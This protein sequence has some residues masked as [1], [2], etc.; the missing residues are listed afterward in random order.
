[1]LGQISLKH[2][3][4]DR[5]MLDP[6]RWNADQLALETAINKLVSSVAD[7]DSGADSMAMTPIAEL[8]EA[9]R[10]QTV[11]EALVTVLRGTAGGTGADFIKSQA[12]SGLAGDTVHALIVA[13]KAY[14]DTHKD[15]D[16]HDERYFTEA[17]ITALFA[18]ALSAENDK[19]TA[20]GNRNTADELALETHKGSDD[21]DLR[22]YMKNAVDA[23]IN[24][25]MTAINSVADF[26]TAH[27]ISTDHDNRYI[28]RDNTL[29]F[30][31]TNGG[32]PATKAYVDGVLAGATLGAIADGSIEEIKIGPTLLATIH[33]PAEDIGDITALTTTAKTDLVAAINEVNAKPT[34][35]GSGSVTNDMLAAEIKPGLLSALTTTAK[36]TFVAAINELVTALGTKL[37][38]ASYTAADVFAKAKSINT[39]S[40]LDGANAFGLSWFMAWK[41]YAGTV[42]FDASAGTSPTGSAV[43]SATPAQAWQASYPT[44]MGWNGATTFGVRVDS[45]RVADKAA[46]ITVSSSAASGGV[47]GDI[48]ITY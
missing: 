36:G 26:L 7:G 35:P 47:D 32:H 3:Y 5:S 27:K 9:N 18:A 17:E 19:V 45:A 37:A 38:S 8:G 42:I 25:T 12:V 20:I 34:T 15:S 1:M 29:G 41:A 23:F 44:L 13:L 33:A 6:V 30:V 24:S 21:H 16:D 48:W 40:N 2:D 22:Y 4:A 11:V 43:S 14:V 10:V 46:N 28:A 39:A 31:P